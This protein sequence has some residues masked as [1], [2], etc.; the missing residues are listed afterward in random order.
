LAVNLGFALN[1]RVAD[2]EVFFIP[3]FLLTA[4]LLAAGLDAIARALSRALSRTRVSAPHWA[5]RGFAHLSTYAHTL[6]LVFLL[7][8]LW[9]ARANY[10][11]VDLSHNWDIRD[12]GRDILSQPL[13][14]N[15]TLIGIQGEMSLLQY[16]QDTQGLR[17]DVQTIAADREPARLA[18]ID[19]ALGQN[20][21]V[22]LTRPLAGAPQKYA[23]T[24]FG[25]LI[26]VQAV[27]NTVAAPS[28]QHPSD[29][30]FQGVRFLGYDLDAS[31]LQDGANWHLSSGRKLRVTLYWHVES[32]IKN[33][34]LVSLKLLG[35][36]G[37]L[38]AQLDL[39]PVLDAY[40]TTAW[41][42]GE[43]ISDT[44]DLPVLMGAAPGDYTLQAT[45]YDPQ[46]GVVY[47]QKAMEKI[48][49]APDTQMRP[50][51]LFD[52]ERHVTRDFGGAVLVGYALDSADGYQAG[53]DIPITLLWRVASDQPRQLELTLRDNSYTVIT[54]QPLTVP[55]NHITGG[56]YVRQQLTLSIP[57]PAPPDPL[58]IELDTAPRDA[59]AC[60]LPLFS[61]CITLGQ[62]RIG[63]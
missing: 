5:A 11:R 50:P 52:V 41:R 45:L 56:Q 17:P 21:S 8:P 6:M 36:N 2:V 24:S 28:P 60:D 63:K 3:A 49:L 25:P 23:L 19:R 1:Y 18:A 44:Y 42:V 14:G 58:R 29:E 54:N 27:P 26:Q 43:Y 22:F 47:G 16:F 38:G 9:L 46:S 40:P 48:T 55:A 51:Q 59:L 62:V 10:D 30:D 37:E 34:R 39:H 13:P 15:S 20:R 61:P 31:R 4:L 57:S 35:P 12:Y 53:D 33:D 32:K 7:L